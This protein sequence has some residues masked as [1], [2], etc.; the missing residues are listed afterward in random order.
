MESMLGCRVEARLVIKETP[1]KVCL[2]SMAFSTG[3]AAEADR[4]LTKELA[5]A[6][7][8]MN[9]VLMVKWD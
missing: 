4:T 8:E 7:T 9:E 5:K 2:F 3:T 1:S 6:K